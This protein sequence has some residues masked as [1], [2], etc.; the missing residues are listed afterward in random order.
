MPTVLCDTPATP[1]Q[2][3]LAARY[4]LANPGIS[5]NVLVAMTTRPIAAATLADAIRRAA[6]AHAAFGTDFVVGDDRC[7]QRLVAERP[8]EWI[9]REIS[10]ST[11]VSSV[12]LAVADEQNWRPF[13][14]RDTPRLRVTALT[15]DDVVH[16][17]VVNCDHMVTDTTAFNVLL[18]DIDRCLEGEEIDDDLGRY[19]RYYEAQ[20]EWL[21][22]P[23]AQRSIAWWERELDGLGPHPTL[24][25]PRLAGHVVDPAIVSRQAVLEVPEDLADAVRSSPLGGPQLWNT[26]VTVGLHQLTQADVV[27]TRM[28]VANRPGLSDALVAWTSNTV[29]LRS[30]VVRGMTFE[31]ALLATR[32]RMMRAFRHSAVP[33][34]ELV[35]RFAPDQ[36]A[37]ARDY[38]GV[39]VDTN[40]AMHVGTP[41]PAEDLS[42]AREGIEIPG[43]T[44]HGLRVQLSATSPT[45]T[46]IR[47]A[48]DENVL[49]QAE[50]DAWC[51]TL[52]DNLAALMFRPDQVAFV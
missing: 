29:L 45:R 2:W 50:L 17:L 14:T 10:S 7:I 24:P 51:V 38:V 39:F 23:E 6:S 27:A 46:E 1:G 47:V 26:A 5:F 35:R 44:L 21:A 12:A 48:V 40:L 31:E 32:K 13:A 8:V 9:L 19:V 33:R 42:F 3:S 30:G 37:V 25:L 11:D 41:T 16:G 43:P 20:S 36:F 15:V 34:H 18:A 22:G 49:S 52:R 4:E 28:A